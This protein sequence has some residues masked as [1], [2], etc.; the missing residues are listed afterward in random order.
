MTAETMAGLNAPSDRAARRAAG[1]AER[2]RQLRARQAAGQMHV[3]LDLS[4]DDVALLILLGWLPAADRRKPAAV[5]RAF[6]C[7]TAAAMQLSKACGDPATPPALR[8]AAAGVFLD[9][10]WINRIV[11]S[12]T[13]TADG[14]QG[15]RI[16]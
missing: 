9:S 4:A 13:R 11:A 6:V 3:A 10:R 15:N 1:A 8:A 12:V 5:N 16:T 14:D 2:M 7:F